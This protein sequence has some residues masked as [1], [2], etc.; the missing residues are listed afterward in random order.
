MVG[1]ARGC[2]EH[3][4]GIDLVAAERDGG[5]CAIQCKFY[6]AGEP[7]DEYHRASPWLLA[8]AALRQVRRPTSSY[9]AGMV[10]KVAAVTVT[11]ASTTS[12]L[13]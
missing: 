8:Q 11:V 3:D 6:G 12:V 2:G 5:L 7:P 10:R 9:R 4:S 13:G 1:V